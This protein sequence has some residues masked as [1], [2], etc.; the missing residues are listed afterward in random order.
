[1]SNFVEKYGIEVFKGVV[2]FVLFFYFNIVYGLINNIFLILRKIVIIG[3]NSFENILVFVENFCF[4]FIVGW[5][6]VVIK[7]LVY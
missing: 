6:Y 2:G 1:M 5:N 4:D 7:F 3:D